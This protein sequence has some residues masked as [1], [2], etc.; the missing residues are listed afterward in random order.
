MT[1]TQINALKRLQRIGDPDSD[2]NQ[3]LRDAVGEMASYLKT[4]I[5]PIGMCPEHV[6]LRPFGM[7]LINGRLLLE[8]D[9]GDWVEVSSVS[10]LRV[11]HVFAEMVTR[12]VVEAV[13]KAAFRLPTGESVVEEP[14]VPDGPFVEPPAPFTMAELSERFGIPVSD[15]VRL[16]R[17]AAREDE[18]EQER[19]QREMAGHSPSKAE[20]LQLARLLGFAIDELKT[21]LGK[22]PTQKQIAERLKMSVGEVRK[23]MESRQ[24]FIESGELQA[25]GID[26]F[27]I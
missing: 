4:L 13:E 11:L 5:P 7:M 25:G 18:I 17:M 27:G 21:E 24:L 26:G 12:G 16:L 10:C 23:L 3:K 6:A 14:M 8:I 15:A 9:A 22:K 1:T 19:I 20:A 2:T